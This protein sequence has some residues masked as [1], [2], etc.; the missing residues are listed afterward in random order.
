M[1]GTTVPRAEYIKV[2]DSYRKNAELVKVITGVRRCGKSELLRQFR[3]HLSESGVPDS[4]IVYI[5]LEAKRYIIDS[6]RMLYSTIRDSIGSRGCYVLIDEVQI[7]RGWERVVATV[8]NEFGANVYITGSNSEM[9]SDE[10]G[11]H[12]TGRFV[13]I[14]VMPFSFREFLC[15]Y[16]ADMDNG[17]TQRFIQYMHWGG[18]PIMDLND[19][20]TK[21]RAILRGVYDSIINHDI[22]MR[23]D[24]E[25]SI[26]E[27]V[28]SF[29]LS[30]T[31]NLTSANRITEG[32]YIGDQRTTE[33]YLSELCRCF[34][35]YKADRFDILGAK[36]MRS[37]AKYYP[38]DTGMMNTI[39]Y[40]H[41]CNEAAMLECVVYLELVRRGYR[42][43]VGSF[44]G[45]EIDFTA[46]N[47]DGR[48]EFYQVALKL[49][50]P[51]TL[52]RELDPFKKLDP[53]CRKL[54]ITMGR[55]GYE[56]PDDVKLVDV[57]DWLL[58]Y[59]EG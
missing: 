44:K 36:H 27:N 16:P 52:A 20:P 6:E 43:S 8:R 5:D 29:M 47:D 14:H 33:R 42:V 32:A 22:R 3:V 57:V 34:V 17:E 11:T 38:V 50:D 12:I 4:D 31:G 23:V 54:L 49:D 9:L 40:G 41:E 37:N 39:L 25:Q 58:T 21:N 35:F 59:P 45:K 53:G 18:M 28:T 48:P 13:Q 46:W 1:S 51:K 24:L 55:D 15:R 7:V 2:L 19:D 10:L 30:N 26:L 56:V